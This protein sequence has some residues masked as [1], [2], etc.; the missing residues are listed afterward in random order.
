MAGVEGDH[1]QIPPRHLDKA[2]GMIARIESGA[3]LT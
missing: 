2:R 3:L 1:D